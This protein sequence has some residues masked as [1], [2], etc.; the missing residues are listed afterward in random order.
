MPLVASQPIDGF[1]ILTAPGGIEVHLQRTRKYKSVYLQWVVER[2]LD[3]RRAAFALLPDLLTRG[4][5]ASPGLAQ[6]AARC[7]DLYAAEVHASVSAHGPVQLLRFGLQTIADAHADGHPVF[8]DAVGLLAE[9]MHDPPLVGGAF[10][11][12]VIEQERTNL[13]HAI[14]GIA[15]DKGLYAYRCMIEAM[16]AGTPRALH[17]WGTVALAEALDEPTV[18]AAWR[19]A[20]EELPARL[21]VVGD[22][23]EEAALAAAEAL[24]GGS[25]HLATAGPL[26]PPV[27]PPRP[28]Q[29]LSRS[30]PLN[31][32]K[33]AMGFRLPAA[34]LPGAAATLFGLVF[35]G[36]SHSRLF[37]RVREKESL[38]YGCS[39]AVSIDNATLVVQ[40]GVDAVSAARTQ[41]LV[42][43]ELARL[44]RD[45]V[46]LEE[47]ELSR[48]AQRR[49]LR[50]LKDS[51]RGLLAFRLSGLMNGRAWSLDRA[52]DEL[53][54]V[55]PEEV[56]AVAAGCELDTVF[57]LE[58][59]RT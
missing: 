55:T 40:A 29:R 9:V 7:E 42:L 31:Q 5:R 10:R 2:P 38:A 6:M 17:S 32:S 14:E 22:V 25:R 13:V 46:G 18:R 47:L 15:D 50:N 33:L 44:A 53:A 11:A 43:E 20:A 12:E 26:D 34:L 16:H 30:E 24:A 49:R 45:G 59:S 51:P 54:R 56:A 21:F 3:E 35:G 41:E 23:D 58:G 39:A 8:R 37:K 19:Q 4:T 1:T 28:V 48:R 52:L 57:L 36:E 27:L